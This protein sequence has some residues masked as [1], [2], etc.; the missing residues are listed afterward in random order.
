[1]LK[2]KLQQTNRN[3]FLLTISK[4]Y[5]DLLGIEKRAIV[6]IE[7]KKNKPIMLLGTKNDN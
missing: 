6:E 1:M 2:Y 3:S 4:P 5:Y 7:Y